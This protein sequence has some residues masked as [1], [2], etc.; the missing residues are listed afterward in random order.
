MPT[1]PIYISAGHSNTDPGAIA[2]H[3]G[4]EYHE[5]TLVTNFRNKLAEY[6]KTKD[7][8][9]VFTDG[10]G[11]LNKDRNIAIAEAKKVN[12]PR[13]D[14]H[15]NASENVT[16]HGTEVISNPSKKKIAQEIAQVICET[17]GNTP[18]GTAGWIDQ[19]Q[20]KRGKLAW[21]NSLDGILIELCFISNK[22]ELQRF[23]Q[24]EDKLVKALGD[25][26][27]NYTMNGK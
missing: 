27:Y 17:L 4:V 10:T 19:S 16:A 15:M 5:A 8:L 21:I 24:N 25:Y 12:G 18:R 14:F 7:G 13:F 1:K 26:L 3:D 22:T 9:S 20:S 2:T 23:F 6:L 11:N